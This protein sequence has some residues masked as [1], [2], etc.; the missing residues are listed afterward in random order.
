[1]DKDKGKADAEF[2]TSSTYFMA[3]N[4]RQLKAID[5]RV[6]LLTRVPRQ[7]QVRF[8]MVIPR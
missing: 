5:D 2:R 3:S 1:M 8:A 4:S 7:H 6:A